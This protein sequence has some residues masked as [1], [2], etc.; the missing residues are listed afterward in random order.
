[1]R[2]KLFII[3]FLVVLILALGGCKNASDTF[4]AYKDNTGLM[5]FEDEGS[6]A[7]SSFFAENLAVAPLV[8][9]NSESLEL[10]SEAALLVDATTDEVLYSKNIFKKLYPASL[11]KLFTA[12]ATLKTGALT[13]TVSVSYAAS[14]ISEAG[15]KLCGFNE[16]DVISLEALLNCMLIY[17][18]ND[19]AI[20]IA[21]HLG[22]SEES[23]VA[24]MNQ[25]A[26]RIGAVHSNF[27]NS[28]G[29]HS[30]EHFTT[31]YD[32]YL[33][34][35]ELIAYDSFRSIINTGTYTLYYVDKDGN[36]KEKTFNST[37]LYF[38]GDKM[39]P[40]SISII[41]GKTGTTSKAGDCLILLSRAENDHEIISVIMNAPDKDKLYEDMDLLFTRVLT[42]TSEASEN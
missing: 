29:L 35:N 6:L 3:P 42:E 2:K 5:E 34:F 28:H 36:N 8:S 24:F 37:N 23:F 25:E 21:D 20:A 32:M 17:S 12:L 15:A 26:E 18:G 33:A 14:H 11:T 10:H 22:G 4:L 31:A 7:I 27:V 9:D 41:G 1:M 38:S 40:D 16:G 30:D 13:D 19:A 39:P